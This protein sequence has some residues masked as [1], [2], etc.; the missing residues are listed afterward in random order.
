MENCF[1]NSN[2]PVYTTVSGFLALLIILFVCFL[3]IATDETF[4]AN[5][6]M[7]LTMVTIAA[8]FGVQCWG[9][10]L[11]FGNWENWKHDDF[12]CDR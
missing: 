9:S 5:L 10:Y 2:I 8:H 11:V 12:I 7:G 3:M 6:S 1:S 4:C